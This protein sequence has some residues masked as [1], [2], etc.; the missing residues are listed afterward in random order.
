MKQNWQMD[1]L[2]EY[3]TFLPHELSSIGNKTGANRLGF[4][5]L[6]KYF[7]YEARFPSNKS[8]IPK[9]IIQY[10]AKQ[11]DLDPNTL[12]NYDWTGRSIQYH[13]AQIRDFF[14]F[15]LVTVNDTQEVTDWLIKHINHHNAEAEYLKTEAYK[16]FREMKIEPPTPERID[17]IVKS[18]I[19]NY[20]TQFFKETFSKIP[21]NSLSK[22]DILINNFISYDD[23]FLSFSELRSDPGR[24][25]LESVF[26]ETKKLRTIQEISLPDDLFQHVPYKILKKYKQRAIS[27]DIRELRRHAEEARYTLL[28]SFFYLRKMEIID[29]I[30][31]L[32]ILIIHRIGVRAER[33]VDKEI[34]NDLKKVSGKTNILFKMAEIAIE[35]PEGTIKD[36]IYPIV[37]EDTLKSLVKEFKNTGAAYKQKVH[38]VMRASFSRHYRRMV[39]EILNVL[40]FRSNNKI[41][42]PVIE[43][44]ELIKKYANDRFIYFSILDNIPIEG[45]IRPMWQ[46]FIIER[47]EQGQ[48]R[49]NRINYEICVLQA[50]RD[51]LRCKEIWAVGAY[52][53]R[54]PDEN[55]PSDFEENIEEHYKALKK[56]MDVELLISNLKKEMTTS[57][58]K[59]DEGILKNPK[60]RI[61]SKGN[62]WISLSPSEPQP[63]SK[64]LVKLK[65][66]IAKLWPMTSLLD[67]LKET[68]LQLSFTDYFKTMAT[69]ERLERSIIQKRLI[70]S[71]Y[72][73]GSNTGLKRMSSGNHGEIYKDL[74]YIKR[75]FII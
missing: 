24:I 43:A 53:Y 48:E 37:N 40:D 2:I 46:N 51:K 9:A 28:A 1:E 57:L 26:I 59:L 25:G 27:E 54:N 29:N 67:I 58:I 73:L 61:L 23:S 42:K 68:D 21:K 22:I 32:L 4:A 65:T 66:E 36:M 20:E 38:T 70:L 33:R 15:K 47:D 55:L 6:F 56:P 35:N 17:R 52:K 5:V 16:K 31:E 8:D 44:L 63:E 69:H 10:I 11:L 60:V 13:K 30:I 75:K 7:Q 14:G 49:I 3:F 19:H 62:G 45:V 41:H 50:L 74:L 71:L 12:Y 64:N 34:I 72:G 18:V 39:P